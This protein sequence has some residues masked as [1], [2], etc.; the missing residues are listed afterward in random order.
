MAAADRW[1]PWIEHAVKAADQDVFN[2]TVVISSLVF[3]GTPHVDTRFSITI[4]LDVEN[5][6]GAADFFV[7]NLRNGGVLAERGPQATVPAATRLTAS[8]T[9]SVDIP[10]STTYSFDFTAQ[11][12]ATTTYRIYS[13]RSAATLIAMPNLH[14]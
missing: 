2:T 14:S 6:G 1:A 7:V 5:I 10:K 11:V 9:F 12:P 3:T 4:D 8:H 13:L